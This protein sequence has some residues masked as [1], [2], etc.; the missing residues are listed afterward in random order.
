M[1]DERLS[2]QVSL[3]RNE[4]SLCVGQSVKGISEPEW[5]HDALT[6][7]LVAD[8]QALKIRRH[9]S[10][11]EWRVH[12]C[13]TPAVAPSSHDCHSNILTLND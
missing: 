9:P 11:A 12:R 13:S 7:V 1:I 3:P 4:Q 10:V 5:T 6:L 2:A 8:P